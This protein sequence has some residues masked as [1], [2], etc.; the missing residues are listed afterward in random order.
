MSKQN[1]DSAEKLFILEN[2]VK[3]KG[4]GQKAVSYSQYTMYRECPYRW[5][6]TYKEKLFPFTSNINS[7][8]GTAL[9]ETLQH[10]LTLLYTVSVKASEE[11]D[12]NEY[13]SDRM[14]ETY[15]KELEANGGEKFIE[16]AELKEYYAD[17]IEILEYLRRKRKVLFDYRNVELVAVELP[18]FVP[19]SEDNTNIVFNFY[20]DLVFY[21]RTTKIYEVWDVKTSTRGWSDYQKKDQKKLDQVLLYK[22]FLSKHY[23]VPPESIEVKFLI[24][25]RKVPENLEWPIPRHTMLIPAQGSSKVKLAVNGLQS[26]VNEALNPDGSFKETQFKKTP[27]QSACRFCPYA[28]TEFCDMTAD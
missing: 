14:I 15:T 18:G 13:L 7:V 27:S 22:H 8:F 21:D 28:G 1:K 26:F 24:V 11:M 10:Y 2:A 12:F 25:K 5:S 23:N 4:E 9:H 3:E 20:I 16:K 19:V 6:L 17:G